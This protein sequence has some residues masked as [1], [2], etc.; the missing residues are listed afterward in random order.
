[1]YESSRSRPVLAEC[2]GEI[3]LPDPINGEFIL[4][5]IKPYKIK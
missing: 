2:R 1:M 5:K 4:A 3:P